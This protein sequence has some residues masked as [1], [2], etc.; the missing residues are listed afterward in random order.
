MRAMLIFLSLLI[1]VMVFSPSA[2]ACY[3]DSTIRE[4]EQE[5]ESGYDPVVEPPLEVEEEDE[6]VPEAIAYVSKSVSTVDQPNV[7]VAG[8]GGL[9]LGLLLLWNM[10]L[11]IRRRS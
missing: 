11:M 2:F 4:Q 6:Y 9:G 7:Q 10:A 5:F 1:A 3:H 8:L